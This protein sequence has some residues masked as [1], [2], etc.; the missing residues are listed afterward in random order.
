MN[1]ILKVVLLI[2]VSVALLGTLMNVA[3]R[4]WATHASKASVIQVE[5]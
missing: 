1:K 5:H 3:V 2:F 4:L